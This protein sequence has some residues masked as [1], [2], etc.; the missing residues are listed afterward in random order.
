MAKSTA[1]RRTASSKANLSEV[2]FSLCEKQAG[3]IFS[4]KRKLNS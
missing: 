4:Y 1:F 3:N 2:N